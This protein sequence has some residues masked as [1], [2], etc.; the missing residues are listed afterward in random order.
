[1]DVPAH[2]IALV[3]AHVEATIGGD[4]EQWIEWP[5]G[6]RGDIESAL[7]DAVFSARA[8]YETEQGRGISHN[9]AD[10]R[11]ARTR[12]TFSLDALLAEIE[13]VGVT[14]WA[15]SFGNLQ[16]SPGRR[17]EAPY[18]PSKAATVREAACKLRKGCVCRTGATSSRR[19]SRRPGAQTRPRHLGL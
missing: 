9:I 7:I 12:S 10:W 17:R 19:R 2:D 5:G 18:G 13:A 15:E 8:I 16:L 1:M 6:W 14:G 11:A 4:P 3:C